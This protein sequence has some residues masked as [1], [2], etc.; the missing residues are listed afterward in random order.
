MTS[1]A[2]FGATLA[3]LVRRLRLGLLLH[4]TRSDGGPPRHALELG[5]LRA[6]IRHHL[7]QRGV[8]RQQAFGQ[9]LK[10]A[11]RQLGKGDL[12]GNRHAWNKSGPQ[13]ADA[14]SLSLIPARTFAPGTTKTPYPG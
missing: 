13:R 7:L 4:A 10:V 2:L 6:Q 11:T 3:G 14:T 9:G 12:L 5:N 1:F 8:L